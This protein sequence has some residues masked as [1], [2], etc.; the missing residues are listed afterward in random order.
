MAIKRDALVEHLMELEADDNGFINFK[1]N[2]Q[3]G[4]PS[5]YS[6]AL[7]TWKPHPPMNKPAVNKPAYSAKSAG[8]N[9]DD[10]PF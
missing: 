7:D 9:S 5:K 10:P 3:K 8:N 4:D 1:V 6:T 2:P